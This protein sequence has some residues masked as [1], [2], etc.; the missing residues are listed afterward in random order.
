LPTTLAAALDALAADEVLRSQFGPGFVDYFIH[1]K[2]AELERYQAEVSEWE[3]R[4]YFN[5]M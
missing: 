3:Q 5:L 2:R 1:L 4:E